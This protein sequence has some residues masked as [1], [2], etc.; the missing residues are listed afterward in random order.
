MPST[1]NFTDLT[2]QNYT[3]CVIHPLCFYPWCL[4]LI[5]EAFMQLLYC[6]FGKNQAAM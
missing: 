2:I 6:M 5:Y 3:V 4:R 1:F